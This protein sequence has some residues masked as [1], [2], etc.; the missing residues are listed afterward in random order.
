MADN[1]LMIFVKNL[2]PGMV[3]TR[4]AE[5]V[6]MMLALDV[7]QEL[8]NHTARTARKAPADRW[9]L[10]SEYVE[11]EDIFDDE[12][13]DY[14]LQEGQ[15]LGERMSRAFQQAFD[16]GYSRVIL[17]GSDCYDLKGKHLEEAF[18]QLEIHDLVVGPAS[19]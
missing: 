15:A 19:D 6:G 13:F 2:V 1:L 12:H 18:D 7:Y 8:V 9:V 5:D 10:Y 11:V 17:I 3:K 14:G 4:L 16:K